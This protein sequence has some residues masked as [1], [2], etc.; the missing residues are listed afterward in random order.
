MSGS[1]RTIRRAPLT[2]YLK[3]TSYAAN[4]VVL[5]L[6]WL[7]IYNLGVLLSD[8][9]ILSGADLI[10]NTLLNIGGERAFLG[11]NVALMALGLS[12]WWKTR[13]SATGVQWHDAVTVSGESMLY[14]LMVGTAVINLLTDTPFLM[15]SLAIDM[16]MDLPNWAVLIVQ[17]AGAAVHEELVFRLFM[18]TGLVAML[19]SVWGEA[20]FI[21]AAMAVVISSVLFSLAHHIGPEPFSAYAFIYRA[22]AGAI[23]SALFLLRGFAVAVYTHAL[24]DI[25]V[26]WSA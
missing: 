22:C 8:F 19:D 26:F 1:L 13:Q 7:F 4:T 14:A 2:P 21:N 9:S 17:A 16:H 20:G 12:L 23:F 15:I 10:T 18:I 3:R 25:Y 5:V 6:P 11:Y 24:Y